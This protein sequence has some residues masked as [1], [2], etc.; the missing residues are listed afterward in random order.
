MKDYTRNLAIGLTVVVAL[1]MLGGMIVIF[2]VTPGSFGGGYPIA[3]QAETTHDVHVGDPI[4]MAGM[5]IGQITDVRFADPSNP[6]KGVWITGRIDGQIRLPGNTAVHVFTKGFSGQ[7]YVS[8]VTDGPDRTDPATGK[9]IEFWPTDASIPLPVIHKGAAMIPEEARE[10]LASLSESFAAFDE[11]RALAHSLNEAIAPPT[12]APTSQGA[13]RPGAV[14]PAGLKGAIENLNRTLTGLSAIVG[15]P[16]NQ[17]NIKVSLSNLA[18]ATAQA[19]DAMDA[20][21]DFAVEARGAAAQVTQTVKSVTDTANIAG[22][23]FDAAA[24]KLINSADRLS[25]LLTTLNKAAGKIESGEGSAGKFINDPKLYNNL[26]EVSD[27]M[28][29]LLKE[30]RQLV[31]K[32]KAS[33]LE[34]KLK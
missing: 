18:K 14:A 29:Q 3:M 15:D 27:Q 28:T 24:G 2:T 11:I 13:T 21:K 4:H 23:R 10:A 31:K 19:T 25:A 32:W 6:G 1:A 16:R 9:T 33:G 30:F 26:I 8:L 7:S 12:T 22:K 34:I 20:L 5:R 17:S